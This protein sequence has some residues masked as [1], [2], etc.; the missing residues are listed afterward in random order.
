MKNLSRFGA[1]KVVESAFTFLLSERRKE[2]IEWVLVHN[3]YQNDEKV[4]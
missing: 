1:A 2:S 4:T 3:R